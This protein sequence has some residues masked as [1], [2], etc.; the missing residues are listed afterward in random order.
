MAVDASSS[1][2]S[3]SSSSSSSSP[4]TTDGSKGAAGTQRQFYTTHGSGYSMAYKPGIL[5]TIPDLLEKAKKIGQECGADFIEASDRKKL[6][7]AEAK[8]ARARAALVDSRN[9]L[10][11]MLTPQS[12]S[13]SSSSSDSASS[14]FVPPSSGMIDAANAAIRQAEADVQKAQNDLETAKHGAEAH[15]RKNM[16]ETLLRVTLSKDASDINER[17]QLAGAAQEEVVAYSAAPT[18]VCENPD[19]RNDDET[20]FLEEYRSGDVICQKCGA[21]AMEHQA[22]DGDWTRNF[23][24]EESTSQIG[25]R[26][27]PLLSARYNLRTGMSAAPGVSNARLRELRLAQEFVELNQ[28]SFGAGDIVEHRTREGYKDKQKRKAFERLETAAE[29]LR[30]ND[31]L[32]T[33]AKGLF[34]AFRDNREHVQRFDEA[35]AAGESSSRFLLEAGGRW[36][37]VVLPFFLV[38]LS[39]HHHLP[40]S[41]VSLSLVSF[42]FP[43]VQPS[44]SRGRR[45]STTRGKRNS[46]GKKR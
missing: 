43:S 7:N 36:G 1:S 21:V 19:C 10:Q 3:P 4:S 18:M 22:F 11:Q 26:P 15:C 20:L 40:P 25:P 2:S 41:F 16:A 35:V 9:K 13:S 6:K 38:L 14:L 44:L 17:Y 27:D 29:R 39:S 12:S 24:G 42:L 5:L 37:F 32:V 31:A 33:K 30:L 34:A 45:P 28:S 8:I 23:E 46:S